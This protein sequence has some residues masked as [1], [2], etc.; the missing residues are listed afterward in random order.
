MKRKCD[1]CDKPAT[2]HLTDIINGQKIE[3]DLCEEC[4]ATEGFSFKTNIPISMLLEDFVLHGTS[5]E[6]TLQRKCEV[7]GTTLSEF[8]NQG[9][10]GCP[11]DYETFE[12][13]LTTLLQRAHEGASQHVG[14]VPHRAGSAQKKMNAVLRLRAQ[15][16][17]AVASEDYEKAAELRDQIKDLENS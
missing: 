12:D 14:K 10:L 7:C 5:D 13:E 9:V 8:R 3:K 17:A 2:V 6:D 15:L 1:K 16:K 11:H 4:A